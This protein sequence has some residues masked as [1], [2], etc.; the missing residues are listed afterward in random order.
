MITGRIRAFTLTLVLII[1]LFI[2]N[3]CGGCG[4]VNDG[5]NMPYEPDTPAPPNHDGVFVSDHGTMTFNGDGQTVEMDIDNELTE[6][7][8]L[9]T[10]D[11]KGTYVFLSGDL[12]PVGSVDVR[13]DVAHEL[14]LR[15][16]DENKVVR[17]GIASE[18]GSTATVGTNMVTEERIPLL[19]D[20]DGKNVTI[21]FTKQ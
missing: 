10:G 9:S 8:G 19:F 2:M 20:I 15:N 14:E 3:I 7:I 6:L 1:A 21:M 12:P 16:G 5:G 4:F 13:Y 11:F 17:V 18:D